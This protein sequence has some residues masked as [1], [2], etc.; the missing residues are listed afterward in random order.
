MRQYEI[1][2]NEA[3]TINHSADF[4]RI[5]CPSVLIGGDQCNKLIITENNKAL[6]FSSNNFGSYMLN[7]STRL[8]EK[9]SYSR[10]VMHKYVINK[11][12]DYHCRNHFSH[13][14]VRIFRNR[15]LLVYYDNYSLYTER[16]SNISY[17]AKV[18]I[19]LRNALGVQEVAKLSLL[20]K[21]LNS[22]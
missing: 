4:I 17:S 13:L 10:P 6:E 3:I 19:D 1:R 22:L 8:Q 11:V 20:I 18:H 15:C 7:L 9:Y 21:E 14:L 16:F 2:Y 5:M 12:G